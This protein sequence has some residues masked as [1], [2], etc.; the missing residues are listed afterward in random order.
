MIRMLM[1]KKIGMTSLFDDNGKLVSV[2]VIQLGPCFV[3]QVKTK[4]VRKGEKGDK[5]DKYDALQLGFEEMKEKRTAKPLRGHFS[6]AGIKPLRFLK[7]V[8]VE[9][10]EDYALGQ[11]LTVDLFEGVKRVDVSGISKGKGFA[12][13]MKR[14]GFAGGRASHGAEWH[15]RTG[16]I[17]CSAYPA[18]VVK[19]QRMP[20]HMG[21]VPRTTR[22]LKVFKVIPEKNLLL[23]RGSIPGA[24]NS[25]VVVRRAQDER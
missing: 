19:G 12:G 13:V 17:G 20:G 21:N 8:R 11:M 15:R 18:R 3:T 16:S 9:K 5:S 6:K 2:S 7:E 22:N 14:Y 1:G 25:Y 10:P 23:V 24:A 4:K